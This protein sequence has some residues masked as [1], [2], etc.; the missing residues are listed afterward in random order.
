MARLG[1]SYVLPTIVRGSSDAAPVTADTGLGVAGGTAT[2]VQRKVAAVGG[3]CA[4]GGAV[5][6][7][8]KRVAPVAGV[9]VA[10]GA[11]VSTAKH[12]GA[13]GGVGTA[14]GEA[15]STQVRRAPQG[16]VATAGGAATAGEGRHA[17]ETGVAAGG[18]TVTNPART[19]LATETGVTTAGGAA[20][21]GE[22]RRTPQAGTAAV[23]VAGAANLSSTI[24]VPTVGV[25]GAGATARGT[26]FRVAVEGGAGAVG[27]VARGT[28]VRVVPVTG[29]AATGAAAAGVGIQR[30]VVAGACTV[31]VV[32]AGVGQGVHQPVG[33]ATVGVVAAA[34]PT[35][36]A[37][38]GGRARAGFTARGSVAVPVPVVAS[39]LYQALT[40]ILDCVNTGLPAPVGRVCAVPGVLAWDDCECGVLAASVMHVYPS[41]AFP[42]DAGGVAAFLSCPVLYDAVDITITVLRCAP[43]LDQNGNPPSC[44]A[45]A[46]SAA[47]WRADAAAVRATLACCLPVLRD[48][49][50]VKDFVLRDLVP[51][52]PE[53]G[54]S[55][56]E[57]RLTIAVCAPVC[58]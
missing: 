20:A 47:G 26:L 4:T 31:G 56:M 49:G 1:R 12:L 40:A 50:V 6:A 48:A 53:G 52:G 17:P 51:V 28:Q 25:S 35:H 22:G 15:T 58:G 29:R 13:P 42:T 8:G 55:G 24:A 45:L 5:T 54:C 23:G 37:T 41:R 30:S 57:A 39:P 33:V 44:V 46:G 36:L 34:P 19:R 21:G 38:S 3:V 16:T 43:T 14:A 10:G 27:A 11:A 7:A 2:G 18:G 9:V 32:A